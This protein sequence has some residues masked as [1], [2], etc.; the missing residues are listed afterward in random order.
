MIG[1]FGANSAIAPTTSSAGRVDPNSN[2]GMLRDE[3]GGHDSSALNAAGSV[4]HAAAELNPV[5]N[6]FNAGYTAATGKDADNPALTVTRGERIQAIGATA[7]ALLP[8]IGIVRGAGA[9]GL[10]IAEGV[11]QMIKSAKEDD[12]FLGVIENGNIRLF[13]TGAEIE[14][15]SDLLNLGLISKNAQGFSM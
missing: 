12:V 4:L 15:H 10:R 3:V 7:A 11:S 8:T 6:T 1:F 2:L 5:V 13:K 9:G 14:G